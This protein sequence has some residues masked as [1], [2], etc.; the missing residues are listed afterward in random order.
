[1]IFETDRLVVRTLD[2]GDGEKYFALH[3]DPVIMRY[4]RA[5]SNREQ[6]NILLRDHIELN[7]RIAPYGRWLAY[8]RIS[9]DFVGSFVIIPIVNSDLMQL[10]YSLLK[11]HWGKGYATELVL[12]GLDYLANQT[13]LETIYAITEE[14]NLASQKALIKAGFKEEMRMVEGEKL[15]RRFMYELH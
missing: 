6:C 2:A 3:G 15:L 1:M 13:P 9:N 8:D 14:E 4:I 12:G 7:K 5:A 10:G 11:E